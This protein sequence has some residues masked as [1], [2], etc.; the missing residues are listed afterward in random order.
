MSLSKY[1]SAQGID[2]KHTLDLPKKN[3]STD[4]EIIKIADREKPIIKTKDI[5][6]LDNFILSGKPRKLLMVSTGNINNRNLLRLFE[7]NIETLKS[8]FQAN[9]V[10]EIDEEEIR[11][12][13]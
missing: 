6:F 12:H 7:N 2:L 9:S 5:D 11:V 4:G 1:L 3:A 8:E 13:Y 10:I